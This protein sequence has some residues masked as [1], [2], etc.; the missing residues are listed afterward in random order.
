MKQEP[1]LIDIFAMLALHAILRNANNG[2]YPQDISRAAYDFAEAMME[3]REERNAHAY[4]NMHY[5]PTTA[6]PSTIYVPSYYVNV[7]IL[8]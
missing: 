2:V 7:L 3:E 1:K 6:T 4:S 8:L 5:S